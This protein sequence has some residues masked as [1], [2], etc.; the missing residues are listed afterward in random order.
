MLFLFRKF[1]SLDHPFEQPYSGRFV[2]SALIF[3]CIFL[4]LTLRLS[5]AHP[6]GNFSLNHYNSLEI[7]PDA[8]I[9]QHV[10]DFAEIPSYNELSRVDTDG[11]NEVSP[12]EM[13]QYKEILR[14]RLLPGW[15]LLLKLADEKARQLKP[16]VIRN[17]VILLRGEGGLTCLLIQM[18][19]IYQSEELSR[20]G[21]HQIVFKDLNLTQMGG[22]HEIRLKYYPGVRFSPAHIITPD[23][24]IPIALSE[25]LYMLSGL[26]L[27]VS[28]QT[29][30]VD[31]PSGL[32]FMDTM[33][34]INP[35]S[36]PQTPLFPDEHGNY[37]VLKSPIQPR[38]EARSNDSISQWQNE[39]DNTPT[40]F[41]YEPA[42][43][44][45]SFVPSGRKLSG[46]E[47]SASSRSSADVNWTNLIDTK[48][49]S[50]P[51]ILLAVGL[52]ILFG[53][54][55]AL[56]PGHGK[57][58]VAAYLVGSRG[59]VRHAIFLG[60]VVTLT[61]V[62]GVFLL[63]VVTLYFS[64]YIVPDKLYP[65][66]ESAAGLLIIAVGM[67]IFL[68]RYGAYQ[69]LRFAESLGIR[70]GDPSHHHPDHHYSHKHPH[71]HMHPDA[72]EH[73]HGNGTHRHEIPADVSFKD[74]LLLGI[75][76]G[77][78]PCPSAVV[79]LVAAIA[80]HR[81]FFGLALIVFFSVGL[82][83]V[84]IGIGI[85]MVSAKWV[86]DRMQ[87]HG[88]AIRWLQIV[89]PV[90]VILLGFIILIRGLQAAG[91]IRFYQ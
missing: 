29:D 68:K 46:G 31:D 61:H 23:T 75:T 76:G 4:G 89:S 11:D 43:A 62:S 50:L 88:N 65:I 38:A 82:A 55:H 6:L 57:T 56:S 1:L 18:V 35:A 83:T 85:L 48:D 63:G 3:G 33:L 72:H 45:E 71:D 20:L 79:V 52:S 5:W 2:L 59:T 19:C 39:L 21:K 86:F 66:I 32:A 51:F 54:S 26:S 58:I 17:E 40:L 25:D 69:K 10:L 90:L 34:L 78:V 67:T 28:Y 37:Q 44:D 80:L 9:T 41:P 36:I 8:I 22:V 91:L 13:R 64:Q 27:T 7:H 74:L 15:I 60:L 49:L 70:R 16:E 12:E 53:A 42:A 77:I 30:R 87:N 24:S 14:S 84:L 81:I 73:G 47:D